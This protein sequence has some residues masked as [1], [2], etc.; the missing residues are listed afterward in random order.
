MLPAK[1]KVMCRGVGRLQSEIP[2]KTCGISPGKA[3][4]KFQQAVVSR[5][6]D[7]VNRDYPMPHRKH[8]D[9]LKT[10]KNKPAV[11]S[12]ETGEK[13]DSLLQYDRS[14]NL[15]AIHQL[16]PHLPVGKSP[17]QQLRN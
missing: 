7:I 6:K 8:F 13:R 12:N 14:L 15:L 16:N 10:F 17:T 9:Q 3:C 4:C 5:G 2:F 11:L 1:T